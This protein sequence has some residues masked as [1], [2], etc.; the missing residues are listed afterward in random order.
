MAKTGDRV[1]FLNATGGGVITRI[2]GKTVYVEDEDGFESPFLL[3][4]VVV[5]LP[6]GHEAAV[7]GS[8]IMFDQKAFDEGKKESVSK[9]VTKESKPSEELT[10]TSVPEVFEETSHGDTPT[11]ILAFEPENLKRLSDT[12]FTGVLVN[13]S[14][15][16]IDFTFLKRSSSDR[17]WELVFKGTVNPNELID[18]VVLVHTDLPEYGKVAVQGVAYKKDKVFSLMPPVNVTRKLDLT[19]F[20]KLHCFR[21]SKYFDT[22]VLEFPLVS[23]G[24]AVE[25]LEIN[26]AK[27]EESINKSGDKLLEKEL[28]KKYRT[29]LSKGMSNIQSGK[30]NVSENVSP[31]KKLPLIEVDLHIGELTDTLSGM[32]SKDMLELQLKEVR[33]TMKAHEKRKGQKIVFIHGKGEGVLRKA[34]LELLKKEFPKSELQDASFREYGFGATLVTVK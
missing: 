26:A 7:K 29:E 4:D 20:H 19:K 32:E 15:Y 3:K 6:A 21:E 13:D 9:E 27:L 17:G 23:A 24:E 34:V 22:P 8:K 5:V 10:A 28:K 16:Y 11:L 25:Q 1:R 14:N 2:E 18:L 30:N 33:D 12:R 31:Y